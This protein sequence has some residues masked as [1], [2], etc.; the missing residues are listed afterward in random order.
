[1]TSPAPTTVA[2]AYAEMIA[3]TNELT[4]AIGAVLTDPEF[5]ASAG[6]LAVELS[7]AVPNIILDIIEIAEC[8]AAIGL[9][10]A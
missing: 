5:I 3:A 1:M 9:E 8:G 6:D 4:A 10:F 2:E 7:V